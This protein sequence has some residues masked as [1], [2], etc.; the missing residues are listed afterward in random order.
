MDRLD[1][2][3]RQTDGQTRRTTAR[4]A[5]GRRSCTFCMPSDGTA[6]IVSDGLHKKA[7]LQALVSLVVVV[8]SDAVPIGDEIYVWAGPSTHSSLLAVWREVGLKR[9]V[10]LSVAHLKH[11]QTAWNML[12][13][14]HFSST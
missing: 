8:V 5:S 4:R 9:E 11:L 1:S 14:A 6:D 10:Q 12:Y 2:Q 7:Q 3:T 13:L